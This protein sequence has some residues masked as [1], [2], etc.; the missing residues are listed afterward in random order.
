MVPYYKDLY[1]GQNLYVLEEISVFNA[2]YL[3]NDNAV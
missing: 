1:S 3:L 2:I